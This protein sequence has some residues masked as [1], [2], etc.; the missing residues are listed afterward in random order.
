MPWV[1]SG[2]QLPFINACVR[3]TND[4]F[5]FDRFK[6]TMDLVG[7]VGLAEPSYAFTMLSSSYND[8]SASLSAS[9][10]ASSALSALSAAL[11]TIYANFALNDTLGGSL[12]TLGTRLGPISGE[13][14]RYAGSTGMIVK[15][16]GNLSG[17]TIVEF[18]PFVGGL[19][20]SLLS[21]YT[22]T[23]G[24]YYM[25]DLPEVQELSKKYFQTMS[26]TVSLPYD[27]ASFNYDTAS[28][29]SSGHIFISEYALTEYTEPDL[30]NYFKQYVSQSAGFFIRSNFVDPSMYLGFVASCSVSFNVTASEEPKIRSPNVVLI[31]IHK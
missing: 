27:T 22:G 14:L 18:G 21:F 10:P 3:A 19:A 8:I 28:A 17:S 25:I 4:P 2:S 20:H 26:Y 6:T 31:G 24:T 1:S 11:A 7:V 12:Y 9:L 16:F 29:P 15:A 23:I 30:T 13:T 5:W